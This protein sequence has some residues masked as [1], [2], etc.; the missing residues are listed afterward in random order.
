MS[1]G[2]VLLCAR[3]RVLGHLLEVHVQ[4]RV[5][6]KAAPAYGP[7]SVPLLEIARHVA[8]EP[9]R[10]HTVHRLEHV[11]R[12]A[13]V[14]LEGLVRVGL[15]DL[16]VVD[17]GGEHLVLPRLGGLPVGERAVQGRAAHQAGEH[18]RLREVELARRLVEVD[19]RRGHGAHRGVAEGHAVQIHLEDLRL[20]VPTLDSK[21]QQRLG[22]LALNRRLVAEQAHLDQ[23]LRD[24]RGALDRVV[25]AEVDERGAR[26]ACRVDAG[27]VIEVAVLDRHDRAGQRLAHGREGLVVVLVA[28]RVQVG[29]HRGAVAREHDRV[30]RHVVVQLRDVRQ[31]RRVRD[32]P[33]RGED[34]RDQQGKK[35]DDAEDDAAALANNRLDLAQSGMSRG[36]SS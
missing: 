30:A 14:F 22:Q 15:R 8:D 34:G 13:Q 21:R 32:V 11:R 24:R 5:D 18:R 23:L 20:R 2:D 25:R 1:P 19:L 17:H 9:R 4:R 27:L 12:R 16:A 26:D 7:A 31:R 33:R 10:E 35:K 3:D 29:Q 36:R 28:G 6:A